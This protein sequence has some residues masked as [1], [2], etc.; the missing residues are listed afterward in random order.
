MYQNPTDFFM[1]LVKSKEEATE[2]ADKFAEHEAGALEIANGGN[3]QNW[4]EGLKAISFNELQ[5]DS[6]GYLFQ[7][8]ILWIRFLRTWWRNPMM[9]WA[10]IGQY[11]FTAVFI[12]LM[13][14]DINNSLETGTFDRYA[15]QFFA[16]V[17]L[18]FTPAYTAATVWD[19]ER[20]LLR[21]EYSRSAYRLTS[22]YIAKTLTTWPMEIIFTMIFSV[23]VYPMVGYQMEA[24]KFFIFWLVLTIFQLISE[25]LGLACAVG[26]QK[27]TYAVIILALLLLILISF[28]GFMVRDI[29]VYFEWI[30]KISYLSIAT[31]TLLKNE[32]KGLEIDHPNGVDKIEGED[33]LS[34]EGLDDPLVEQE[35]RVLDNLKNSLSIGENIAALFGILIGVRLMVLGLLKISAMKR[36][37]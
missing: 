10:E 18:I 4:T 29:P 5:K 32:F 21:T 3:G 16:L 26:T 37:L 7:A 25:A 9:F 14:L 15:S 12:G 22:Y 13:Y 2:L 20:L 17:A 24:G 28:T 31:S 34:D 8:W 27:S 19:D 33:L 11:A 36:W 1:R 35:R 6:P 30:S 23:I